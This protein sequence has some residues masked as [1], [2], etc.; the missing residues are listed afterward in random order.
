MSIDERLNTY[1]DSA[2]ERIAPADFADRFPIPSQSSPSPWTR[3][4]SKPWLRAAVWVVG[5]S[6]F[7]FRFLAL[8]AFLV[9]S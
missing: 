4:W 3:L 2:R 8:V 9:A 7:A 1:I 5:T 6:I